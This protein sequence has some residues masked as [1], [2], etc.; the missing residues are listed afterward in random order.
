MMGA[1]RA[2]TLSSQAVDETAAAYTQM[3]RILSELEDTQ[4]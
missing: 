1:E 3:K 2:R 4:V